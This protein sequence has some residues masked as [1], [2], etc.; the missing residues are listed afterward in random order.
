M[1][2]FTRVTKS[3][4]EQDIEQDFKLALA[5]IKQ[6]PA[7]SRGGVYL[8]YVYYH[9]LFRKIKNVPAKQMLNQGIRISNMEKLR[10]MI[11]SMFQHKLN[12]I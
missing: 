11:N 5:G 12:L 8:A 7:S 6:L 4:I 1:K 2:T 10:L 3:Q 9:A